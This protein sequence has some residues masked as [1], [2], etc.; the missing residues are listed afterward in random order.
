MAR[1]MRPNSRMRLRI[2]GVDDVVRALQNADEAL[3]EQ[4]RILVAEAAEIVF[5][6]ADAR[7]P[8]KSGAARES[9][10]IEVGTNKKGFFYANVVVGDK[11]NRFYITFYELGSSHQ[12][13]RPF[14]RPS[15]DKSKSKI[16]KHLVNGLRAALLAQG[17]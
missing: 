9:L 11:A 12:P 2:E 4:L 5:R 17:T 13:P 6:E 15:L 16:R 14:L 3:K 1:R 8:I 7:V 10:K